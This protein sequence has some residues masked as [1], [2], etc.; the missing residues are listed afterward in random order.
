MSG[1]IR[2][3]R[4]WRSRSHR[5]IFCSSDDT[6]LIR[7]FLL[8]RLLTDLRGGGLFGRYR[9]PLVSGICPTDFT[10]LHRFFVG[11]FGH[12]DFAD[13][14]DFFS[15]DDTEFIRRFLLWR[16]LMDFRG[17]NLF[18]RYRYPL[19]SDK[20]IHLRSHKKSVE[21]VGHK[22]PTKKNLRHLRNLRDKTIAAPFGRQPLA[23]GQISAKICE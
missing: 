8:W 20:A 7:R 11:G 22:T 4:F 5:F 23:S 14:A 17:C 15:S 1:S 18:G 16:L 19:R 6:E 9:Y 21:S 13:D 10:D 12:A 2:I 3:C